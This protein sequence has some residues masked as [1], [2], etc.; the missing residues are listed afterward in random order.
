MINFE[1]NLDYKE[2]DSD[3]LYRSQF[4]QF[5]KIEDYDEEQ[6]KKVQGFVFTMIKDNSIFKKISNDVKKKY[7]QYDDPEYQDDFAYILLYPFEN[8]DL[9]S[10]IIKKIFKNEDFQNDFIKLKENIQY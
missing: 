8:F 7:P 3:E 5:F 9:F 2:K 6:I 1:L 4:L 10:N